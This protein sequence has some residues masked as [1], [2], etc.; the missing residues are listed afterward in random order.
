MLKSVLFDLDNTLIDR[1]AAHR[2]YCENFADRFLPDWPLSDRQSAIRQMVE[3]D[4][5]GYTPRPDYFQWLSRLFGGG[6]FSA[7]QLWQDYQDRLPRYIPK[8]QAICGLVSRLAECYSI[9]IVTNGSQ[10]NQRRKLKQA[11]LHRVC[12]RVVISGEAG[13]EKPHP[14]IFQIAMDAVKCPPGEVLF[15]GDDPQNDIRGAAQMGMKTCWIRLGRQDTLLPVRAD[16]Q[17]ETLLEL[18][19]LLLP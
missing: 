1:S 8:N 19:P 4:Q 15:V 17:I 12:A 11:G 7:E 6:R 14:A 5:M 13:F 10:R 16:Y 2:R 9:A 3:H 18:G